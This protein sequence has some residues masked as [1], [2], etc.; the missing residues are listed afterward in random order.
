[1]KSLSK[2]FFLVLLVFLSTTSVQAQEA[3]PK[4]KF[5]CDQVN[6][7]EFHSL[8]PYQAAVCGDADK[9]LFCSNDLKFIES[10]DLTNQCDLGG[11]TS[12]FWCKPK[13]GHINPHNLYVELTDSMFPIMGNTEQVKNSQEGTEEFSDAQKV[14][15][16]A[17]WYLSGVN[18][19]AEYGESTEDR[20]VNFSGPIQKL[21]PKLIQEAERID[22]IK[23]AIVNEP[24]VDEDTGE[25]ITEPQNHNQIVVCS[26]GNDATP[27]P[28]GDKL[29]LSDWGE[30]NLSVVNT[31]FNWIGTDVWNYKYPPLPW[32]F[33]EQILYQKAY[34]EWQGKN[35]AILPIVGL[36][37]LNTWVSNKWANLYQYI[38]LSNTTDKKGAENILGVQIEASTGTTKIAN[39]GYNVGGQKNAPLYFAHTEEVKELSNLLNK[40]YTPADYESE[41]LPKTTEKLPQING[42]DCSAVNVRTNKGDNLFPGDR[43]P[44][45]TKEIIIPGVTYDITQVLCKVTKKEVCIPYSPPKKGCFDE[46]IYTYSCNAEVTV[47]VKTGTKTPNAD[48]IFSTT[49]ADSGSTFRKIFP[50][51]GEGS[52][53]TCIADIPTVTGVTYNAEESE[54]PTGGSLE[55]QVKKY[56]EDGG[57][58]TPELTFPHVGSVYEYFLKGIQTALRPKGYG[59]PIASGNCGTNVSCGELPKLS[60]ASGSCNL[61]GISSRVGDIPQSL[62]DIVSAAAETYK[63]P[64]NLILGIMFGEGLFAGSNKKDWTDENVK[65]W[66]T[67]TLVPGCQTSGDDHLMGFN[68]NTWQNVAKKIKPDL[69]KLDPNR[70]EPNVCNLLDAVY[71]IA[72]DLHDSADGGMNF[73]CF[74]LDLMAPIPSSCSWTP[75]QYESAIKISGSGVTNSCLTK[76]GSCLTGGGLNA[77]CPSG[78]NCEKYSTTGNT[79]HNACVWDVAH[80]K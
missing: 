42:R 34:N 38:P 26:K 21:L 49:V 67:C 58:N 3:F 75:E 60:K 76:S 77:A 66:S 74:G 25:T 70:G 53:V 64:P 55:F 27:C 51:V 20:V 71:G 8:R 33:S 36:Q 4:I 54:I 72:W 35:C 40:T 22:T 31:F 45:D 73:Q 14:N 80:G 68:G 2:L 17:S 44:G 43:S 47:T 48:E 63:V 16:Y 78:D 61:G 18:N 52:P 15:E 6:D 69:Q 28:E 19:K 37:C 57:G 41:P 1:M 50:K 13:N 32:Q 9:A 65:N 62:K 39:D 30:G 46:I 12:D 11:N 7:P 29:R 79:S 5:P 24:Y 56:P 10:F 59:E 23:K